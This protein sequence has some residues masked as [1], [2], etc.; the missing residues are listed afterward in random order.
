MIVKKG[1]VVTVID[2]SYSVCAATGER[3]DRSL[4]HERWKVLLMNMVGPA[5]SHSSDGL[6]TYIDGVPN[7]VMIKSLETD[8][9]FFI[10]SSFLKVAQKCPH[11]GFV[12]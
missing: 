3:G 10:R 9:I 1:D 5:Q 8:E 12:I 6:V 11:C 2:G 4:N 7:D